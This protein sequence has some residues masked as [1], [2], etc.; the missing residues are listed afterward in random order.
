L[1]DRARE[2]LDHLQAAAREMIHAARAMLDVAEQ[3]VND[4]ATAT[5]IVG[6]LGAMAQ[7]ATGNLMR[8]GPPAAADDDDDGGSG[9]QH[10][11]VRRAPES[12]E[13]ARAAGSGER[14]RAAGSG[15][16]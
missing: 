6:A 14:A 15:E 12:G 8:P 1:D 7:A 11:K 3:L 2:G 5:T 9:V 4:P 13:R 16:S 10:I